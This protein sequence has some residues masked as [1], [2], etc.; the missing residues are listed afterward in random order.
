MVRYSNGPLIRPED[1]RP[2]DDRL[3]VIGVFNPG[4][5]VYKDQVLLLLRVAVRPKPKDGKICVLTQRNGSFNIRE[6]NSEDFD[7]SDER[8]HI[9]K[10]EKFL[11][12]MSYFVVAVSSDGVN[13]KIKEDCVLLPSED[14]ESFGIEDPRI[15]PIG[16]YYY[17]V[18][19]GVSE[20]G[21]CGMLARTKDFKVYEKLG[22]ILHPDNKDATLFPEKINGK[23]YMLH[24]PTSAE[25]SSVN[26]WI[27]ESNSLVAWGNHK[28]IMKTKPDGWDSARIGS[29]GVPLKTDKGWLVVYHGADKN[30][31]YCLGAMLLDLNEPW[32]VIGRTSKPFLEPIT[33]CERNGFFSNVVFACGGISSDGKLKIYYG[34]SDKY[35][36]GG[37]IEISEIMNMIE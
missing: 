31:R 28:C 13:F 24:R 5:T 14:L 12:S 2:F 6:M 22:A 21:I 9:G 33:G 36:C 19:S 10:G 37:E 18:Y 35:V 23:Y 32:K 1:V 3:E 17:I 8:V 11:S 20:V 30:N 15:I 29:S 27:A 34:A 7:C 16:D 26:I 4:V 25:F